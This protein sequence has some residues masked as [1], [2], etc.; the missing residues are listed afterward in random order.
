[1]AQCLK[2]CGSCVWPQDCPYGTK[3]AWSP[4]LT[5]PQ[6]DALREHFPDMETVE[7]TTNSITIGFINDL[8]PAE[9]DLLPA[10]YQVIN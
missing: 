1:M 8:T 5:E 10:G 7:Q 4:K 6:L 9:Y 3:I 2:D